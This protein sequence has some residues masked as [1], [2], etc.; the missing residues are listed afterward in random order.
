MN[1]ASTKTHRFTLCCIGI[2]ASLALMALPALLGS[3]C[4][5]DGA[6]G[7]LLGS[8]RQADVV[9]VATPPMPFL[10][11]NCAGAAAQ[12]LHNPG[13]P[14]HEV[15][16][17]ASG[18]GFTFSNA[19][20]ACGGDVKLFGY[21]C[22]DFPAAPPAQPDDER[23]WT[24][25]L[26]CCSGSSGG[27]GGS[28]GTGGAGGCAHAANGTACDDGNACTRGDACENGACTGVPVTNGTPC[29]DGNPATINDVCSLGFCSGALDQHA[30]CNG[31]IMCTDIVAAPGGAQIISC[32]AA[33]QQCPATAD[34]AHTA[35]ARESWTQQ[36]RQV[37]AQGVC[38]EGLECL[39][40]ATSTPGD[41][42]IVQRRPNDHGA[43]RPFLNKTACYAVVAG[44]CQ[45]ECRREA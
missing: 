5:A 18:D 11:P 19:V 42:A 31:E 33:D 16:T 13:F 12:T 7:E 23:A 22:S 1:I 25:S 9:V 29:D 35:A 44:I 26:T 43:C 27:T 41:A 24:V 20:A 15:G 34:A 28:T 36:C 32:I 4:R 6:G 21:A 8:A 40:T 45:C 39:P 3:G 30:A 2:P 38:T 10:D 37:C 17:C 14:N